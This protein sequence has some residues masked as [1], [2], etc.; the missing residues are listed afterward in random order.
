MVAP[1]TLRLAA[2]LVLLSPYIPLLWMGEEY[3][4][5]TPWMF[6]CSFGEPTLIEAVR[7]G[8]AQDFARF[9]GDAEQPDPQAEATFYGSKL[10]LEL[11]EQGAHHELLGYYKAVI[12]LRRERPALASLD[13]TRLEARAYADQL[14]VVRRWSD[15]DHVALL[16]NLR[17][18]PIETRV[19]LPE[20][21]WRSVFGAAATTDDVV[22]SNG[23]AT[24][25]LGGHALLVLEQASSNT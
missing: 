7:E 2:A 14:L 21:R 11:R 8:R 9:S 18:T 20:G 10:R 22:T 3:G 25:Q 17:D 12:A 24:V 15:N 16:F 13:T 23:T 5:P 19:A 4:D 1:P 6:F